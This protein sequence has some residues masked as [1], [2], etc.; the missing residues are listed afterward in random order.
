MVC[1]IA[2]SK[3]SF[4]PVHIPDKTVSHTRHILVPVTEKPVVSGGQELQWTQQLSVAFTDPGTSPERA[5][6]L[7]VGK[8]LDWFLRQTSVI[9][10]ASY[11]YFSKI[12][13]G[14]GK[15]CSCPCIQ[16]GSPCI[17]TPNQFYKNVPEVLPCNTKLHITCPSTTLYKETICTLLYICSLSCSLAPSLV[18]FPL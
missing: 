8:L 12:W 5:A 16:I 3:F 10:Q 17:Q 2:H 4:S 11:K 13:E 9:Y 7:Q 15:V 6:F 1:P 14:R 18:L